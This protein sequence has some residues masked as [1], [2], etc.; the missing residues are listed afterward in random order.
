MAHRIPFQFRRASPGKTEKRE[1]APD[2]DGDDAEIRLTGI[3]SR[4]RIT[5]AFGEVPAHL[6]RV[7]DAVR[8]TEGHFLRIRK[9][10]VLRFD[11]G[12]LAGHPEALP[13]R[14][15]TDALRPGVPAN[16]IFLAPDQ[17]LLVVTGGYQNRLVVARDLLSRPRVL[18]EPMEQVAYYRLDL[19]GE[20]SILAEKAAL[21]VEPGRKPSD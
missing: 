21:P 9:I 15:G 6:L 8:V 13:I 18:R 4:T 11:A 14:I 2:D 10:D 17:P 5:T 19:G 1:I 12:F 20:A 16:D 7:N 3:E